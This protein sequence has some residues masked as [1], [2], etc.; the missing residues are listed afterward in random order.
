MKER[1]ETDAERELRLA[2]IDIDTPRPE[3][4]KIDLARYKAA[5]AALTPKPE[6]G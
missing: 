1:R 6:R 3:F 4:W 5:L 2:K